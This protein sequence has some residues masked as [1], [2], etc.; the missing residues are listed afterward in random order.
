[1]K[2]KAIEAFNKVSTINTLPILSSY[3]IQA[4]NCMN[5]G[6][7]K[8]T[9]KR[10]SKSD[11]DEMVK[12]PNGF[13]ARKA[14]EPEDVAPEVPTEETE[15]IEKLINGKFPDNIHPD[16]NKVLQETRLEQEQARVNAELNKRNR[17]IKKNKKSDA[18]VKENVLAFSGNPS[19]KE[20]A[21]A[22][23]T[24]NKA[25]YKFVSPKEQ[26]TKSSTNI[27]KNNNQ[28][29]YKQMAAQY[30]LQDDAA[31]MAL[32]FGNNNNKNR[33]SFDAMLPFLLMQEQQNNS[34]GS[35]TQNKINPELIKT[36]MMSQMMGDF[37][38]G[39]DNDKD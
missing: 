32:M 4:T 34:D 35:T 25:G 8:C 33:N 28:N 27:E 6:I 36:M 15:D 39:F 20:I 37:D 10:Y 13:F 16:A 22:V 38:M 31:Q 14:A 7:Q 2:H 17:P 18:T 19:D 26:E 11:I 12:D 21:D 29:F 1:M 3:A 9:Y 23:R 5:N 24:V 30:A